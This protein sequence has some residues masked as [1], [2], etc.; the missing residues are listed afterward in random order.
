MKWT[1]LLSVMAA[2]TLAHATTSAP[3]VDLSTL[4]QSPLYLIEGLASHGGGGHP[5]PQACVDAAI[6][7]A[8]HVQIEEAVYQSEKERIKAE[9][10]MKI[11]MMDYMHT[12][13]DPSSDLAAA[14]AASGL[15]ADGAGKMAANHFSLG[16]TILYTILTPEQR[17]KAIKCLMTLHKM[18]MEDKMNKMCK[19]K[20]KP[21]PPVPAPTPAPT[22]VP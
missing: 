15:V 12:L 9:S 18:A 8:Q 14:Q 11:A 2:G 5:M 3:P 1:L 10:D 17:P 4:S 6:T 21:H 13:N 16:N 20:P 19:K 7:D 22:P